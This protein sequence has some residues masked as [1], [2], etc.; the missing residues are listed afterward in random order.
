MDSLITEIFS[1]KNN[2]SFENVMKFVRIAF[3]STSKS[4][5]DKQRLII[6]D[7]LL[8]T[9]SHP[10]DYA[11]DI[12]IIAT[13][14]R[15][16]EIL[17]AA[18]NYKIHR[19]LNACLQKIDDLEVL[20]YLVTHPYANFKVGY[21][22]SEALRQAVLNYQ[23]EKVRIFL[24]GRYYNV[25]ARGLTTNSKSAVELAVM[26]DMKKII[27]MFLEKGIKCTND[28][29][30]NFVNKYVS[31]IECEQSIK[32]IELISFL[33]DSYLKNGEL[34]FAAMVKL[35]EYNSEPMKEFSTTAT[36]EYHFSRIN[37]LTSG[38]RKI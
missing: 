6:F 38:C 35:M 12:I 15:F 16:I 34:N 24:C 28:E 37:K 31:N 17:L 23:V 30:N 18:L 13:D 11:F 5:T 9:V 10:D 1:L 8:K 20:R 7:I 21:K 26:F 14:V 22:Q 29:Y 19:S 3:D 2:E 33:N 32:K 27:K 4:L 25:H 36:L